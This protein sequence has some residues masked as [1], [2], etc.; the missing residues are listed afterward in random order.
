MKTMTKVELV[1]VAVEMALVANK[2]AATKIPVETLRMMV[3][4]AA[5]A[6]QEEAARLQEA[7]DA[8]AAWEAEKAAG[9]QA[10]AAAEAAKATEEAAADAARIERR[11]ARALR[12]AAEKAEEDAVAAEIDALAPVPPSVPNEAPL[13]TSDKPLPGWALQAWKENQYQAPTAVDKAKAAEARASAAADRQARRNRLYDLWAKHDELKELLKDIKI[14]RT[15]DLIEAERRVA[16]W[17]SMTG[18]G[19][20]QKPA[21]WADGVMDEGTPWEMN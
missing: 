10:R 12:A 6:K 17:Q 16:L 1:R 7:A 9:V 19:T 8:K 21:P 5:R 15:A 4:D 3:E 13:P 11:K 2:T 18:K 14:A 20:E